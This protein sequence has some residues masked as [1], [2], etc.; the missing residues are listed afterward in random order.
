LTS[1]RQVFLDWQGVEQ[2]AGADTLSH[3][4]PL[5]KTNQS[6]PKVIKMGF[7]DLFKHRRDGHHD[8]HGY[9]GGHRDYHHGHHGGFERYLY[10]F[11]KLKG[12][13]KLWIALS[14]TA[15]VIIIVIIAVIIMLMPVL[16]SCIEA[17]QKS[18]I[19]GLVETARPFLESLWG[20]KGK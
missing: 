1:S 6:N 4:Q 15:I 17:I 12:N 8:D 2:S 14:I 13:R 11:E 3:K 9:Y 16:I 20:G 18:G 7:D 19:K 10:L 5:I